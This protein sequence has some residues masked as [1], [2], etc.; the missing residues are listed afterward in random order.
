[1][2]MGVLKHIPVVIVPDEIELVDLPVRGERYDDQGK[3]DEN[4]AG[5]RGAGISV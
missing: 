5:H 3:T 1:M 2:D 4:P